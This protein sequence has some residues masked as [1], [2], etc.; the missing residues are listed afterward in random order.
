MS[1]IITLIQRSR[2][3]TALMVVVSAVAIL[4]AAASAHQTWFGSSLNHSP[5]NAGNTCA[6]DGVSGGSVCTHVGSYYPGFSGRTG[7]PHTGTVVAI[8]LLADAPMTARIR[9]VA[10]RNVASNHKSGQAKAV[11]KGP[12]LHVA[13]TGNVE[14]FSVHMQIK[15]GQELALDTSANTAEYCSD[16]TPGQLLFDP[17]LGLG[18][19]YRHSSGVDGCLMLV[20]GVLDY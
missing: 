8:K 9:V 6:E 11:V 16:G 15:R 5:A 1:R 19:N 3:T 17:I 4:P 18:Q 13:G 12:V 2:L 14:R 10:V 20:Q 7:S